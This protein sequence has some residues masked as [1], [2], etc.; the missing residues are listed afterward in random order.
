RFEPVLWTTPP[1]LDLLVS[2]NNG[3]Y[4]NGLRG[5]QEKLD[6]LSR[7]QEAE[8]QQAIQASQAALQEAKKTHSG[9]TDKFSDG[10]GGVRKPLSA[11]LYQPIDFAEK[12]IPT[13]LEPPGNGPLTKFCSEIKPI[14]TKYPFNQ[15]S[16]ASEATLD[17]L[18]KG[19]A[20]NKGLLSKYLQ[21]PA[22]D[23]VVRSESGKGW[24][25]N[26]ALKDMQVTPELID[27]VTR[28]QKVT[29]AFFGGGG[30]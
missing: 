2:G 27:F 25:P 11:L 3:A 18:V 21:G 14:L 13:H 7:A 1:E 16:S 19:F 20:P 17:D 8:K 30:T 23:L 6:A 28:A 29:D 5:L 24:K 22:K 15:K 12:V 26:P 4:I 10:G 9:L